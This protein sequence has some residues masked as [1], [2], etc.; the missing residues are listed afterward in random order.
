MNIDEVRMLVQAVENRTAP[1]SR[2]GPGTVVSFDRE[3]AVVTVRMDGQE[4]GDEIDVRPLISDIASNDRVMIAYD[5]PRGGYL[6][7]HIG[8]P[9]SAGEVVASIE[10]ITTAT[11]ITNASPAILLSS[12]VVFRPN[13]RYRIEF[14]GQATAASGTPRAQLRLLLTTLDNSGA[15]VDTVLQSASFSLASG[16]TGPIT[17]SVVVQP[18]DVTATLKLQGRETL[19]SG[20]VNFA[21]SAESPSYIVVSDAGPALADPAL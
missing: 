19:P 5:P 16:F 9:Y 18:G 17:K 6:I 1:V 2:F 13:R 12:P 21:A 14:A 10:R 8:R 11:G 20:S 15:E 4:F 7:G 3:N